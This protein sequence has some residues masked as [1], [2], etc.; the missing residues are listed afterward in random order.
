MSPE[1]KVVQC[2]IRVEGHSDSLEDQRR[3][4]EESAEIRRIRKDIVE[5]NGHFAPLVSERRRLLWVYSN[6]LEETQ[7]NLARVE[8]L[9]GA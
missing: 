2:K 6:L 8:R 4:L 1:G 5:A 9:F 3:D 7:G